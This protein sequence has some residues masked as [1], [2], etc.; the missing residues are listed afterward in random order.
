MKKSY[1]RSPRTS[2]TYTKKLTKLKKW[3]NKLEEAR[4]KWSE[5]R[6]EKTKPLQPLS[7]YVEKLKQSGKDEPKKST[8][9]ISKKR[10]SRW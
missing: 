1:I 8:N 9:T 3:H 5:K 6:L 10:N 4:K 7:W 2:E